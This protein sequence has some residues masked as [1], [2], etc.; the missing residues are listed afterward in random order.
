MKPIE[1]LLLYIQLHL[2]PKT[3]GSATGSALR[4]GVSWMIGG[5]PSGR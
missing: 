2:T 5:L 3:G 1:Y 4:S